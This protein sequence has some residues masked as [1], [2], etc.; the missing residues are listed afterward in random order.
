L[1]S[2]LADFSISNGLPTTTVV[3]GLPPSAVG[4]SSTFRLLGLPTTTIDAIGSVVAYVERGIGAAVITGAVIGP[5]TGVFTNQFVFFR[6]HANARTVGAASIRFAAI[7]GII[8]TDQIVWTE[9]PCKAAAGPGL[10]AI[11]VGDRTARGHFGSGFAVTSR[12]ADH[13][14]IGTIG[15][16]DTDARAI[17]AASIGITGVIGIIDTALSAGTWA[18]GNAATAK[19]SRAGTIGHGTAGGY[20]RRYPPGA[21]ELAIITDVGAFRFV[22]IHTPTDADIGTDIAVFTARGSHADFAGVAGFTFSAFFVTAAHG[23]AFTLD[24][25][26]VGCA[27]LSNTAAVYAVEPIGAIHRGTAVGRVDVVRFAKATISETVGG[28]AN[29][30]GAGITVTSRRDTTFLRPADIV[31]PFTVIVSLAGFIMEV[32]A[33]VGAAPAGAFTDFTAVFVAGKTVFAFQITANGIASMGLVFAATWPRDPGTRT[34]GQTRIVVILS[35]ST[36]DRIKDFG[37]RADLVGHAAVVFA[38]LVGVTVVIGS[39]FLLAD[40]LTFAVYTGIS[41]AGRT[42]GRAVTVGRTFGI[43]R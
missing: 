41:T 7:A 2:I 20:V 11:T 12:S 37:A 30:A 38:V 24:P 8:D 26:F 19:V 4:V 32:F 10:R 34:F 6:F 5:L 18:T 39:A 22:V 42:Q 35:I 3:A 40:R 25:D 9:K 31:G 14:R 28:A 43:V 33:E 21:D 17:G 13:F 27:F 36:A 23:H 29:L 1:A 16:V 15:V